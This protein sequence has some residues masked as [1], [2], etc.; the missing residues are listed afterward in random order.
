LLAV[1]LKFVPL[2]VTVVP[3]GPE[4]GENEVIVGTCAKI[5]EGMRNKRKGTFRRLLMNVPREPSEG[6]HVVEL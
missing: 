5:N 1:V 3:T 2:I 4:V 6:I